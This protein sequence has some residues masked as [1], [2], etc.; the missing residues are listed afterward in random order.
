MTEFRSQ[1]SAALGTCLAVQWLGP[2]ASTAGVMGSVPSWRTKIL[3]MPSEAG[4][5][6]I[7]PLG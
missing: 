1:R 3:Q 7:C 2:H 6:Q 4:G 5:A